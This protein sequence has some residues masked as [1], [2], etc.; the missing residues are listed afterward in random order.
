M[1]VESSIPTAI[2]LLLVGWQAIHV[3]AGVGGVI[4]F[5]FCS[6]QEQEG[7]INGTNNV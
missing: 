1:I 4:L 7:T 3:A 2:T 5:I 6:Y